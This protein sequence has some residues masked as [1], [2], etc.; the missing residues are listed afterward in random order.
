MLKLL[1]PSYI[2]SQKIVDE[3]LLYIRKNVC[4]VW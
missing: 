1:K 2:R 3:E 4:F